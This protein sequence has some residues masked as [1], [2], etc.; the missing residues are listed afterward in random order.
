MEDLENE[1]IKE[2]DD[3]AEEI[4]EIEHES[5]ENELIE[6]LGESINKQVAL[7]IDPLVPDN[8]DIDGSSPEGNTEDNQNE[9]KGIWGF[10]SKIPRWAYIVSGIA[11][12]IIVLV[13]ILNVSGLGEKLVVKIGSIFAASQVDYKQV[14]ESTI[15]Y[16]PEL[17][18]D[19]SEFQDELTPIPTAT[20]T[21]IPSA[22]PTPAPKYE[23]K[24]VNILLL[25]E[26]NIGGGSMTRGRT[27]SI[28]IATI[29]TVNKSIKLTS[30]MRD[31]Y[32]Q[33][34]DFQDNRINAAYAFGGV[35]LL[36]KT[37]EQNFGIVP[38]NYALVRFNDFEKIVDS[39][40]GIDITLSKKEANYLNKTN[41]IS[42]PKNR[43]V[44]EGLNHM[45]G[46]QALGYSRI[47]YVSTKDN[48]KNDFGRTTRHREVLEAIITQVKK[49]SYADL[50]KVGMECLPLVTTDVTAEAIE[51]YANMVLDMGINDLNIKELRI[52]ID[53]SYN[54]VT[55]RKMSVVQIN[56]EKNR[57][58][59]HEFVYED[60]D[61][62]END[63][64]TENNDDGEEKTE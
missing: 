42:D 26:E 31:C 51:T 15:N 34:P 30:I 35:P 63:A 40:G 1:I 56:I 23:K 45:N 60:N 38:D 27:D 7:E 59:L 10:I 64:N 39:I 52:P 21:P 53:G 14:D 13:V 28:V 55:I 57:N 6:G 32:V 44:K 19:I 2:N 8:N 43:N 37:I 50:I 25:G 3:F 47:R 48:E 12:F 24:T 29:D 17:V 36:Y 11:V 33:I 5:E 46:N 22:T 9:K 62:I 20:P 54:F 41:Y 58:A 16:M 4:D 18:E 61:N 49:L